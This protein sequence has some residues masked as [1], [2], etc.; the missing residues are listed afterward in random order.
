MSTSHNAPSLEVV[1]E[2]DRTLV[3]FSGC[4]SLN[5]WNSDLFGRALSHLIDA[6]SRPVLVLDLSAIRYA[7]S[8]ALGQFVSL[9]RRVRLAGGRF[10]LRNISPAIAEVLAVTRLDT[11][12]EVERDDSVT[13]T[14]MTA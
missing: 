9:N 2:Q 11:L 6:L 4:D 1:H 13:P 8:R 12:L 5:E 3:R 14:A 10:V 7:T